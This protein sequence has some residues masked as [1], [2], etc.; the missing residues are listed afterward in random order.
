MKIRVACFI[1]MLFLAQLSYGDVIDDLR[2]LKNTAKENRDLTVACL[3][4]VKIGKAKGWKSRECQAYE[5]F[6]KSD[7]VQFKTR[8]KELSSEFAKLSRAKSISMNRIKQGLRYMYNI[9]SDSENV[10]KLSAEIKT[11]LKR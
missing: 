6:S 5:A 1:S 4:E 2:E 9:K 7:L 11:S 3:V 8:V 10:S